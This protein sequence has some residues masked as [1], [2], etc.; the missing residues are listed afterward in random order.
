MR[1][2]RL[3]AAAATAV[4]TSTLAA[5][6]GND[7][8]APVRS[9]V[10]VPSSAPLASAAAGI[11]FEEACRPVYGGEPVSYRAMCSRVPKD[12]NEISTKVRHGASTGH[13][14][15]EFRDRSAGTQVLTF[16]SDAVPS[17]QDPVAL[18]Q[19]KEADLRLDYPG[20]QRGYLDLGQVN[21]VN[22]PI[23]AAQLSFTFVK[24][25]TKHKG[26]ITG[27]AMGDQLC[28]YVAYTAPEAEY[29]RNA[30]LI[31]QQATRITDYV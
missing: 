12:W 8:T 25:G 6:S 14:R 5:C 21:I 18:M 24:N 9:V 26:H 10:A 22:G 3:L 30:E 29:D 28:F 1:R 15:E 11:Q 17:T 7:V 23:P 4:L 16:D 27:L 19:A 2:P 13:R 20:Y 31:L